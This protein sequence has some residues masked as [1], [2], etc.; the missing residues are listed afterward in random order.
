MLAALARATMTTIKERLAE[1]MRRRR[2]EKKLGQA[3]LADRVGVS[4]EAI[5]KIERCKTSP[6][7]ELF[8][9]I[10]QVLDLDPRTI[11]LDSDDLRDD[12]RRRLEART[13][14]VIA[15]L[16]NSQHTWLERPPRRQ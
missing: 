14:G 3:D 4:L 11:L 9:R 8:A 13:T 2:R 5:S 12:E 7:V 16:S 6:S 10:V 1:E 15:G